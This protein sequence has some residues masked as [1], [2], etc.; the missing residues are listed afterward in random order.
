MSKSRWEIYDGSCARLCDKHD[1]RLASL[2][3]CSND[4]WTL[5][6]INNLTPNNYWVFEAKDIS[7]AVYK[8]TLTINKQCNKIIRYASEI[9]DNLPSLLALYEAAAHEENQHDS[10]I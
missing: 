4:L 10:T 7:E 9:R 1:N 3:K 6:T 5:D 2:T 8:A